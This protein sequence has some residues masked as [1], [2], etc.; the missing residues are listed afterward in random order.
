MIML[1][2]V[3]VCRVAKEDSIYTGYCPDASA[4]ADST[5]PGQ[6]W[7]ICTES[8][9]LCGNNA[10]SQTCAAA[11]QDK[12]SR[13]HGKKKK[14]RENLGTLT[15]GIYLNFSSSSLFFSFLSYLLLIS[16]RKSHHIQI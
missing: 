14:I 9:E 3:S 10:P 2:S 5:A 16:N 15:A 7:C 8:G 11:P 12:H 13:S 1:C 4:A 6:V